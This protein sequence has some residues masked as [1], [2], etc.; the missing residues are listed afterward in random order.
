MGKNV[1]KEE[2]DTYQG[3][4]SPSTCQRLHKLTKLFL[5]WDNRNNLTCPPTR[6]KY[7]EIPVPPEFPICGEINKA[8]LILLTKLSSL[9]PQ[10]PILPPFAVL[11]LPSALTVL[12][13]DQAVGLNGNV[14]DQKMDQ[15]SVFY[16]KLNGSKKPRKET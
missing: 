4:H 3:P 12:S 6:R 8:V 16:T 2:E 15:S 10:P 13:G 11:S 7:K 9:Q 1:R 5:Q 14:T